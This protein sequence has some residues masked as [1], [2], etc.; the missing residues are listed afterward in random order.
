MRLGAQDR[1]SSKRRTK[2]QTTR[3]RTCTHARTHTHAQDETDMFVAFKIY[4]P[5]SCLNALICLVSSLN[6]FLKNKYCFATYK[7]EIGIR[8]PRMSRF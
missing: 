7:A 6:K 2:L 8:I 3:A 4:R 1:S 5:G